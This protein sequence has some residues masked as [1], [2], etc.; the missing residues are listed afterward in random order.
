MQQLSEPTDD[1]REVYSTCISIVKNVNLKHR[2]SRI[3]EEVGN[4]SDVYL[5][6]AK[7]SML[8]KIE[9]KGNVKDVNTQELCDV[10]T[11]RMAKKGTPGRAV[12][13]RLLSAPKHSRCPLCSQ[14]TVS[15]LDHHLPKKHFPTFAVLPVNL[16]P[17]CRDCNTV[18]SEYIPQKLTEQTFHPYFDNF[19]DE[20]WLSALLIEETPIVVQFK[21]SAPAVWKPTKVKRAQLHF[22]T[23]KLNSL[24]SSH[25][26]QE[27]N[28]I[29]ESITNLYNTAKS[30]GV[31][32]RLREDY[33][34]RR[35]VRINS[36]QTAF[37]HALSKND[38][39]CN[40]GF[41]IP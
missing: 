2:L 38:W 16:V 11:L 37:Y 41:L 25:A 26:A 32:E 3:K 31:K 20:Q 34:S 5:K 14:R 18:K 39:Y 23:F 10:Y 28:D 33:L 40:G 12:Y 29:R 4:K 24:Y 35:A 13:D 36:W 21:V 17:T 27:L 15:T 1:A 8:Y 19:D 7:N 30:K 6:N 22:N 9:P